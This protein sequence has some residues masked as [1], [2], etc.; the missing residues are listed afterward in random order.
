MVRRLFAFCC[1]L[2]ALVVI[3]GQLGAAEPSID[4]YVK[5]F[6]P[7]LYAG[8]VAA[9]MT[10]TFTV[11]GSDISHE[12]NHMFW[13]SM[14]IFL[15]FLILPQVLL[16]VAI[17]RFRQKKGDTRKPATWVHN[18]RLEIAWTVI[19][20]LA[21]IVVGIP[22]FPLLFKME[23]PPENIDD[24]VQITVHGHQFAWD[25]TY[26]H[27]GVELKVDPVNGHQEVLV[28]PV[29]RTV[30][31]AI[32]SNDVNHAW[33]I[34][35]FGVK[36]D[37]IIGRY[38]SCWF[39]PDRTGFFKG[40]CAELC[41]PLHG[42][43][44]IG[45]VVVEPQHYERWLT[46]Q[47]HRDD[48]TSVWNALLGWKAGGDDTAVRAAITKYRAKSTGTAE[49]AE[50]DFALRYWVAH[51]SISY[52]RRDPGGDKKSA[53]FAAWQADN[54]QMPERKSLVGDI[55]ASLTLLPQSEAVVTASIQE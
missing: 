10:S 51:N 12:V 6:N 45:A 16:L 4:E 17:F 21:L 14:L 26:N 47:K 44:I 11:P 20:V 42:R 49:T 35:A 7:D 5:V 48:T 19:P 54:L 31:L 28:F 8:N 53:E 18:M 9:P 24:A 29:D 38:N 41:G 2:V 25:Y 13:F 15:P 37:A 50:S 40:Q 43:M 22:T 1:I 33:W 36:K 52:S 30:S 23:L 46:L 39:T 3:T 32:T 55:L 27:E 34:P